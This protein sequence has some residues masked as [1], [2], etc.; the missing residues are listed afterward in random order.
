M[1]SAPGCAKK[2]FVKES[3]REGR[4]FGIGSLISLDT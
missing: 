3:I 4:L 1:K 2:Y